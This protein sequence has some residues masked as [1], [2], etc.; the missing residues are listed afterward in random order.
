MQVT[1]PLYSLANALSRR[2]GVY[3]KRQC[4]DVA[5][6]V[7]KELV[8]MERAGIKIDKNACMYVAKKHVPQTDFELFWGDEDIMKRGELYMKIMTGSP[9]NEK[10]LANYSK[11]P[12]SM[13]LRDKIVKNER[14]AEIFAHEF[15]HY[16]YDNH[17]P[18]M[19]ILDKIFKF[20]NAYNPQIAK[21]AAEKSVAKPSFERDLRRLLK[22]QGNDIRNK[23]EL[24]EYFA[25]NTNITSKK[26][27]RAY[28]TSICRYHFDRDITISRLLP[29]LRLF[30]NEINSYKAQDAV[31]KYKD[32]TQEGYM[33]VVE[34]YKEARKVV[35]REVFRHMSPSF[36]SDTRVRKRNLP[37]PV[38]E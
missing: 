15:Q 33:R 4:A 17:T 26:R 20:R 3:T 31:I 1:R 21:T 10:L 32:K 8:D 29:Q 28:I 36:V 6:R 24:L 16:I 19:K 23:K 34:L 12:N 11:I 5:V 22:T 13:F 2:T 30:K 9:K 38:F 37:S 14:S 35:K 7:G 18:I 25:K 27:L